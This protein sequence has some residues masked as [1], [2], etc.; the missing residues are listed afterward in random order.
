LLE[1][2]RYGTQIHRLY[3][4]PSAAVITEIQR[5]RE[6]AWPKTGNIQQST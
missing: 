1:S 6:N 5:R 2:I 4:K 3:R